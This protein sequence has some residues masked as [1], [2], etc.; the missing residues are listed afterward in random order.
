[1]GYL[2]KSSFMIFEDKHAPV[3]VK[4]LDSREIARIEAA[5]EEKK[6][7]EVDGLIGKDSQRE[8][9]AFE[10]RIPSLRGRATEEQLKEEWERL[11]K[12]ADEDE[13]LLRSVAKAVQDLGPERNA[14]AKF[15]REHKRMKRAESQGLRDFAW[16]VYEIN[17]AEASLPDTRYRPRFDPA[18]AARFNDDGHLAVKADERTSTGP[19]NDMLGWLAPPDL[20]LRQGPA[21]W[22]KVASGAW[23]KDGNWG[24]HLQITCAAAEGKWI[25][26]SD[27]WL[28]PVASQE[29]PVTFYDKGNYYEIWQKTRESGRPL[30]VRDGRLRF[31]EGGHPAKFNIEGATWD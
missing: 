4:A 3:E 31:V 23:E 17:I 2:R 30:V 15:I 28:A 22:T 14:V 29:E 27:G 18:T 16:S 25:G 19:G 8:L 24:G 12:L 9:K 6:K 11:K 1:M 7:R 5:H 13:Q 20:D 26:S 10:A 21:L